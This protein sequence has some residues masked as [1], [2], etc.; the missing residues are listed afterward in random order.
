VE[1]DK[2]IRFKDLRILGVILVFLIICGIVLEIA[3]RN[4]GCGQGDSGGL[5][6]LGYG[7]AWLGCLFFVVMTIVL[8]IVSYILETR[9]FP[10]E[11]L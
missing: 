9:K 3:A 2:N 4:D 7:F 5:G 8:S 1:E 11:K 6:C 10:V